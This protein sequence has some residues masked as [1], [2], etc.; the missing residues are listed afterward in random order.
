MKHTWNTV[1]GAW[2]LARPDG[3][4]V[5]DA[6][7]LSR[8]ELAGAVAAG[9]VILPGPTSIARLLIDDWYGGELPEAPARNAEERRRPGAPQRS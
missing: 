1:R 5:T 7:I 4:E 2:G 9:D 6:V 3:E 8:D